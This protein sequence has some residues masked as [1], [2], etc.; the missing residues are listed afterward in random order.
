MRHYA[1]HFGFLVSGEDQPRIDIEESARQ[2][3]GV[4]HIRI[5]DPDCEGHLR[6]RVAHQ[7]LADPVDI[8]VDHGVAYQLDLR[9]NL[10][11]IDAAA[12]HLALDGVPVSDAATATHIAVPH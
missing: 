11:S 10:L 9:L 5:D 6:V 3:H 12:S 7:V 2:S 4:H 1:G 8:F